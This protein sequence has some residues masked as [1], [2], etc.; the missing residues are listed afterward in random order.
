ML[1]HGLGSWLRGQLRPAHPLGQIHYLAQIRLGLLGF[2]C[3][4]AKSP[5]CIYTEGGRQVLDIVCLVKGF[6]L[7]YLLPCRCSLRR[8]GLGPLRLVISYRIQQ[9]LAIHPV[10]G[11]Q[12]VTTWYQTAQV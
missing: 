12:H 3:L 2:D 9:C 8:L 5:L 6:Y 11:S 1:C 4:G 7:L 10:H